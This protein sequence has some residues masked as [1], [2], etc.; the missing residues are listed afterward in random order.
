V[1]GRHLTLAQFQSLM[2]VIV[3]LVLCF[4]CS[5]AAQLEV[6]HLHVFGI[7]NHTLLDFLDALAGP[8]GQSLRSL[9]L[10]LVST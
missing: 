1:I 9:Q 8:A 7:C 10:H 2:R 5:S 4:V 3:T 6:L